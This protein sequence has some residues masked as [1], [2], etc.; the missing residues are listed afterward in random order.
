MYTN[1][2]IKIAFYNL[3]VQH[4][5]ENQDFTKQANAAKASKN[6]LENLARVYGAGTG[7][8]ALPNITQE[9]M[10]APIARDLMGHLDREFLYSSG[11]ALPATGLGAL[12]GLGLTNKL[13]KTLNKGA[14]KSLNLGNLHIPLPVGA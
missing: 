13:I 8:I 11:L 4:A 7:A 5:L 3:G 14:K 1:D 6:V 12:G 10:H 2:Q 9:L